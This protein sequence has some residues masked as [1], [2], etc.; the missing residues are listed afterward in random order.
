VTTLGVDA[1]FVTDRLGAGGAGTGTGLP[2][3]SVPVAGRAPGELIVH[4]KRPFPATSELHVQSTAVPLPDPLATGL[5]NWSTTVTVQ[6]NEEL[7]RAWKRTSPPRAPTIVGVYSFGRPV[8]ETRFASA[9]NNA[10]AIAPGHSLGPVS[11]CPEI[12]RSVTFFPDL[13]LKLPPEV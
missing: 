8:T 2:T 6:G 3:P 9:G 1:R 5:P 4:V 7:S 12:A 10:Y 13:N 11:R